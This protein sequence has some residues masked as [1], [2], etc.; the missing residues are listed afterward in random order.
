MKAGIKIR[1]FRWWIAGLL[2]LASILNYIDRQA[3]SI[4]IPTIQKD[5]ALSDEQYG[6][7]VSLFLVAYTIAYLV[8]GRIVDAIGPRA[9]PIC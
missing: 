7:V 1:N 5:L 4:L 6:N 8:S 2:L 3:L 9:S